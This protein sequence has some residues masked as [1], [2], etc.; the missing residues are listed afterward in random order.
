[1]D[2]VRKARQ[3]KS[4]KQPGDPVKATQVLV[5]II[6]APNP[7]THLLLGDDALKFV[8][9]KLESLSSEFATLENVTRSTDFAKS[10]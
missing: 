4:G 9:E 5:Q 8:R 1:M 6:E 2:P 10:Q 3:D 7:P